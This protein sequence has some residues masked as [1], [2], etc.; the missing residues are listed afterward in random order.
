VFSEAWWIGTKEENP[1]ELKLDFP[2]DIQKVCVCVCVVC[3][4]NLLVCFLVSAPLSVNC[5]SYMF[6]HFARM[7]LRRILILKVELALPVAK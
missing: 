1:E 6:L 2:E 5:V 7:E 4:C 3:I